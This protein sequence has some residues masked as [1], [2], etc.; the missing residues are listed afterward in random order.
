MPAK[1]QTGL[2]GGVTLGLRQDCPNLAAPHTWHSSHASGC[3]ASFT[4]L[5]ACLKGG[6]TFDQASGARQQVM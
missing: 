1:P 6:Y 2:C 3:L 4:L 5:V